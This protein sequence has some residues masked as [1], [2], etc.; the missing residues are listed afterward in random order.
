MPDKRSAEIA[1]FLNGAGWA[2]ARRVPL[3]GDASARRYERLTSGP[4]GGRAVLMDAPPALCPTTGAFVE[5]ATHLRGLGF[6][7]PRIFAADIPR[8]LL[9]LEDLGDD[10]FARVARANPGAAPEL[11]AA[12]IDVLIA[13]HKAPPPPDLGALENAGLA[14]MIGVTYEWYCPDPGGKQA[15]M[16]ALHTALDGIAP[17]TPVLALRDFHAEN[18]IW[19]PGRKGVAR[20]GLLDFQDAFS[21]HPAYDLISLT[22]DARRDVSQDLAAQISARYI[23]ATGQDAAAFRRASAILAVQRNL[24]ILGV[25]ARLAR[26]DG[27]PGY[28]PFIPRVWGHLMRDLAHPALGDLRAILARDLPEPDDDFLNKLRASCKTSPAP[29]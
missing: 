9:L 19:L 16:Q 17:F 15:A 18:L 2:R 22:R 23:A 3:A 24:R 14:R 12:A 4:G 8:G 25:F 1:A 27:K 6:S 11:Y 28:I 5:I 13:L 10:L 29:R 26:R 20:V 21:G 7:A